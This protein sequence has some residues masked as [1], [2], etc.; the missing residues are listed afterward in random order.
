[1][2]CEVD[3][4]WLVDCLAAA[5]EERMVGWLAVKRVGEMMAHSALTEAIRRLDWTIS[6]GDF[7]CAACCWL[8]RLDV[9]IGRRQDLIREDEYKWSV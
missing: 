1:M 2:P 6:D 9:K 3:E 7:L 5:G 4:V 8:D